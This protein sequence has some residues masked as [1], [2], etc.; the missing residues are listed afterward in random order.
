MTVQNPP[1]RR[2]L[3]AVP[4]P[5]A[6][7]GALDPAAAT[8]LAEQVAS[9]RADGAFVAGTTGEFPSLDIEERIELFRA[10]RAGI[11]D[12]RL[13]GHIGSASVRESIEIL[14]RAK[15]L[16]LT[17]FAALTPYF[18]PTDAATTLRYYEALSRPLAGARLYVYLFRDRTTTE[19]TP[20]ELAAIAQLPGIVGVK[21]SGLTMP[22]V[23]A[24]RAAVPAEFEVYTG[25]DAD[26]PILPETPLTGVV[27]GVSSVF[28]EV[29]DRMLGAFD[30][31]GATRSAAASELV[32]AVDIARGD[33]ARLKAGL[34]LRG[35]PVGLP[36]MPMAD[37]DAA[38]MA[39]LQ[40]AL[41]RYLGNSAVMS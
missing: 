9:T 21:V 25:S 32:T 18:L 40:S 16:G 27:S 28:P 34:A 24:Y 33:I 8:R 35:Q 17:E 1:G 31:D 26:Y 22:Q 39:A 11:G 4:T 3:T 7:D 12:K 30:C 15:D 20:D 37:P 5:F 14:Q 19:V 2:I 23:L 13:I 10:F 41:Q 6:A 29:F 38:T 36:R